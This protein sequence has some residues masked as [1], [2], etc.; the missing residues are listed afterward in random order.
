MTFNAFF[1]FLVAKES[2]RDL[3]NFNYNVFNFDIFYDNFKIIKILNL[4]IYYDD[5]ENNLY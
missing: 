1:K 3:N 5:I 4:N 2:N